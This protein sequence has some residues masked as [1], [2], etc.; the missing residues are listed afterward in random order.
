MSNLI[1]SG[2]LGE[3]IQLS[4]GN[5]LEKFH[6]R[7]VY[8]NKSGKLHRE[9]GPAVILYSSTGNNPKLQFYLNGIYFD[10]KTHEEMI[11]K[12]IIE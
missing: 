9:D 6:N 7:S 1:I 8:R 3:I 11:I 4:N 5:Y 12:N 2:I 10:V